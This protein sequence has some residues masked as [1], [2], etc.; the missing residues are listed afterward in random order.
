VGSL[1]R[2]RGAFGLP[3]FFGIAI[4][5]GQERR[6]MPKGWMFFRYVKLIF[7][8]KKPFPYRRTGILSLGKF[9]TIQTSTK[10]LNRSFSELSAN[11][12]LGRERR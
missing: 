4:F 12:K 2:K 10:R 8:I 5:G 6:P 9:D 1:P 11:E 3:F 7:E